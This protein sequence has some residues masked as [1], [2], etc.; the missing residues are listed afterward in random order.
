MLPRGQ[1]RLDEMLAYH[2]RDSEHASPKQSYAERFQSDGIG[3]TIHACY[4]DVV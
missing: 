1:H 3:R 4:L 2:T